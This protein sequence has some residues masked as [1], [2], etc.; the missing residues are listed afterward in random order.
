MQSRRLTHSSKT[1]KGPHCGNAIPGH[2]PNLG[3][4]RYHVGH[5]GGHTWEVGD[6]VVCDGG[7]NCNVLYAVGACSGSQLRQANTKSGEGFYA[8]QVLEE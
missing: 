8:R 7:G 2:F 4:R 5:N 3:P 6:V 1:S